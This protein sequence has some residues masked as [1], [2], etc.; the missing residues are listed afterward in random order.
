MLVSPLNWLAILCAAA[1]LLMPSSCGRRLPPQ[2]DYRHFNKQGQ[3]IKD[4]GFKK[5]NLLFI[6]YDDLRPELSNYGK[7]HMI[8]PNFDRLAKKSV[9]FT[10][11]YSQVAVCNPSRI[12]LMTG[13]RPD[14]TGIFGFES[15][16]K[17]LLIWPTQLAR[18]GY[19]T[20]GFGKIRH[21]EGP[22]KEVW[23]YRRYDGNPDWYTYQNNE[24]SWM[25][26]SVMPDNKRNEEDFP[27]FVFSEQ[28]ITTMKEHH[29]QNSHYFMIGLGFKMPH[30]CLHVPYRHFNMYKPVGDLWLNTSEAYLSF[31]PSTPMMGYRCCAEESFRY[32]EAE[33]A[34][35]STRFEHEIHDMNKPTTKVMHNELMRAYSSMITFTDERLG[36]VLDTIDEL[37]MW[38]NITIVLTSDHGMHNGEKSI[39]EKWTLFEESVWVPLMIYHPDSPYKGQ[40]FEK[41]VELIDIFPTIIDLLVSDYDKKN[42][43]V[44]RFARH[45]RK[46]VPLHG[47]SLAPLVLGPNYD[48]DERPASSFSKSCLDNIN[49]CENNLNG[50]ALSQSWRCSDF[51][52]VDIDPRRVKTTLRYS[53]IWK[54][55]SIKNKTA[56]GKPM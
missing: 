21:H 14:Y 54:D 33:G 35:L 43:Y 48:P 53:D 24:W 38:D 15:G 26:S 13:L 56:T 46:F 39:W 5:T 42:V 20:S 19:K 41:P 23:N 55:C 16:Y 32:M 9:T 25:N 29:K 52:K 50:F 45:T 49:N 34:A 8:T 7:P 51:D 12:S 6:I 4:H 27:D 47:K 40:S 11:A 22:D 10:R 31:P 17:P 28:A 1:L 36:R 30:L 18:S 3:F 2:Y 44:N 37:K